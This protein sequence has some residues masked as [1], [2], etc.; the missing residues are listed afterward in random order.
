MGSRA[1]IIYMQ[2][3]NIIATW[4]YGTSSF[5][6]GPA[7]VDVCTTHASDCLHNTVRSHGMFAFNVLC[8]RVRKALTFQKSER[9]RFLFGQSIYNT[10]YILMI[11]IYKSFLNIYL[12]RIQTYIITVNYIDNSLIHGGNVL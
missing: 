6:S 10:M 7:A 3:L 4:S 11:Y 2:M 12:Q 9:V 1:D 8:K 5:A